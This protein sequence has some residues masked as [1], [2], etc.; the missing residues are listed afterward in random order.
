MKKTDGAILEPGD[1]IASMVLD[2]PSKVRQS[3]PFRGAIPLYGDPWPT[4]PSEE[5]RPHIVLRDAM[6]TVRDVLAGWQVPDTIV[7]QA[8][9]S[10]DTLVY[11]ERLCLLEF[12]EIMSNIEARLPVE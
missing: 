1:L 6:G 3:T 12:N 10:I 7:Q 8:L 11:D 4:S 9:R 2:D 5:E